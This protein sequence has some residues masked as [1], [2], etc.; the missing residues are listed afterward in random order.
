MKQLV[1]Q[2]IAALTAMDAVRLDA[3]VGEL[4]VYQAHPPTYVEAQNVLEGKHVLRVLLQETER[5][6][7][8]LQRTSP[9]G[10]AAEA[11]GVAVY[12]AAWMEQQSIEQQSNETGLRR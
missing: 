6:L 9:C 8:L 11:I 12:P 5:N 3:L 7:R 4:A 1:E 10:N 2:A